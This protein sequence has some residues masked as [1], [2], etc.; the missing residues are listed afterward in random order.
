M[1][2]LP[3][4]FRD[5]FQIIWRWAWHRLRVGM[6]VS[7]EVKPQRER[8]VD[9]ALLGTPIRPEAEPAS[10]VGSAWPGGFLHDPSFPIDTGEQLASRLPLPARRLA[11]AA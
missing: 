5:T 4:H 6:P 10:Q 9:F 1:V 2:R 7:D 8:L 3:D 11:M